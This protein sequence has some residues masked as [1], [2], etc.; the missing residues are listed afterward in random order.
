MVGF[1]AIPCL[2]FAYAVRYKNLAVI[3]A[4]SVMTLVGIILNRL[5]VSVIAFKW[6]ESV[7]YVPTWGEIVVT[8]AVVLTEI[9]VFRWI[10]NRMPV[11]SDSPAW[12]SQDET[13]LPV[14]GYQELAKEA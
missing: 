14:V 6:Y 7:R 10:V 5:N 13:K 2:L 3:R 9:W 1:V 12:V 11:L 4:A 8:L